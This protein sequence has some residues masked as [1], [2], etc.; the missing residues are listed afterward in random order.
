VIE[1]DGAIHENRKAEDRVR[2]EWLQTL[3]LKI[4]RF[5]NEDILNNLDGVKSRI[6]ALV[7]HKGA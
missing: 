7:D 1:V 2:T 4:V 5:N 3:G 6:C